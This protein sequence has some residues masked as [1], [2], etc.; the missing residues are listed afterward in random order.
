MRLERNN[1]CPLATI[2]RCLR[3]ERVAKRQQQP[4]TAPPRHHKALPELGSLLPRTSENPSSATL[5]T[6]GPNFRTR[7]RSPSMSWG[8]TLIPPPHVAVQYA[9]V[10]GQ[11]L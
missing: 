1:L 2:P 7:R 3:G 9:S 4:R 5:G 6:Y 11:L 8:A 10:C